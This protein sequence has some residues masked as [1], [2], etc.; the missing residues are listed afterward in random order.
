LSSAARILARLLVLSL[1][2]GATAGCATSFLYERADRLANRWVNGYVDLEP[3]QQARLEAGFTELHEWH[4]RE[5]L[6][7]YAAWLRGIALRLG[8]AQPVSAEELQ[9]LG[10]ELGEF[11]R[12]LADRALPALVEVGA[13]LDDDQVAALLSSLREE[14]DKELR[15]AARRADAWHQQRR[16]RSMERF[17]KRWTG[18]LS[19]GQRQVVQAWSTSLEPSRELYFSNRLGWLEDLEMA[20]AQRDHEEALRLAARGL[21][22]T[23][24]QRWE[25]DYEALIQRNTERTTRFMVDFLA[26]LEPRQRDRAIA[27]LERLAAEF[28]ALSMTDARAAA[29]CTAPSSVARALL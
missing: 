26:N 29:C 25:P 2:L 7:A 18:P 21:F 14:R 19:A 6:P 10:E 11:W 28:E 24:S 3:A 16:A 17:L 12:E 4:R 27:R 23:P 1:A 20:L 9:L 15:E 5:H 8:E 13:G 22:V